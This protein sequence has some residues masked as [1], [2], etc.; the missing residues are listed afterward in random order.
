[1]RIERRWARRG[2]IAVALVMAIAGALGACAAPLEEPERFGSGLIGDDAVCDAPKLVFRGECAGCHSAAS[3]S[4]G[5]DLQSPGVEGRVIG[6]LA[7]GGP[8]LLVNPAEPDQS[9]I[10]T[11]LS[12]PPFGKRMPVGA[13]LAPSNVTCVRAWVRSAVRASAEAERDQ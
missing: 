11:K 9:V 7:Q 2:G 13:T 8:G 4:G 12:S 3:Q 10:V 1:M 5:L 6:V